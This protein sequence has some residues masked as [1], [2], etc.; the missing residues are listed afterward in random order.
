MT[1][2]IAARAPFVRRTNSW[3][4]ILHASS[5]LSTSSPPPTT[6]TSYGGERRSPSPSSERR[7]PRGR[8]PLRPRPLALWQALAVASRRRRI[9]VVG[10]AP[11]GQDRAGQGA[12]LGSGGGAGENRG[13]SPL[14]RSSFLDILEAVNRECWLKF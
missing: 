3:Y 9:T 1:K 6:T 8:S 10:R 11:V 14:S 7:A 12:V 5:D 2:R 4:A 13:R